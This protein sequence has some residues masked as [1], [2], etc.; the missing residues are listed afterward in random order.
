M[1]FPTAT[2]FLRDRS[3]RWIRAL[4]AAR[5]TCTIRARLENDALP[6]LLAGVDVALM[7]FA[8]N[9]A[10]A[11][12]SPTKTLEYF[13]A[14]RPVVSTPIADVVAAYGDIGISPTAPMR[15]SRPCVR[16]CTR[17]RE[18]VERGFAAARAQTWDAIFAQMWNEIARRGRNEPIDASPARCAGCGSSRSTTS[19]PWFAENTAR[20]GRARSSPGGKTSSR[21]YSDR[22]PVRLAFRVCRSAACIFR[23]A[24]DIRFSNDKTPYKTWG[25]GVALTVRQARVEPGYYMQ[26]SPG[27]TV[28]SAGI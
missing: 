18:R 3:S 21:A 2:C 28:V 13:A 25:L 7:P 8:L 23:L 14:R 4:A 16:R 20:V 27:T 24:R 12:I 9:R 10:T 15:S 5:R 22:R 11:S 17:R 1:R 19:A 6:S 26:V